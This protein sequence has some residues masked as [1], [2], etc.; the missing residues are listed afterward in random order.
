[1]HRKAHIYIFCSWVPCWLE[2]ANILS[3]R[4]AIL[5]SNSVTTEVCV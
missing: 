5:L 3:L 2:V 1:M 4:E